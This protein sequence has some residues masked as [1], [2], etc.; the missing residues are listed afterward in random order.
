MY[1]QGSQRPGVGFFTG[2]F[3]GRQVLNAIALAIRSR[4]QGI[5][6]HSFI[7]GRIGPGPQPRPALFAVTAD[8]LRRTGGSCAISVGKNKEAIVLIQIPAV[9]VSQAPGL[10]SFR[11]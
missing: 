2:Y 6:G 4:T 3:L 9:E 5:D 10:M 7:N 8:N 11:F 1:G